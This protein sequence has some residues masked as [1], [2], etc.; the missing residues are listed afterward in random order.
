MWMPV[1]KKLFEEWKENGNIVDGG[2]YGMMNGYYYLGHPDFNVI[3]KDYEQNKQ[4]IDEDNSSDLINL[5]DFGN[6][7][8]PHLHIL[9]FTEEGNSD[10]KYQIEF[11]DLNTNISVETISKY[12]A[13][14]S[15]EV[16]KPLVYLRHIG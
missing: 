6:G 1:S 8:T 14:K 13:K 10:S 2:K 12:T 16:G 5:G 7:H 15:L 3:K 4:H 9:Q 11:K